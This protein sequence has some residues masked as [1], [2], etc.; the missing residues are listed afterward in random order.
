MNIGLVFLGN[1]A[2]SPLARR[3]GSRP[4]VAVSFALIAAGLGAM[5]LARGVP[6]IFAGEILMGLAS[7]IGYPVMMGLSIRYVEE[8]QRATAMGLFQAVYAVGMFSGPWLSGI[9]ADEIGIQLM[10]AIT[11]VVCLFLGL[12][13]TR[14]LA[15]RD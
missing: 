2:V 1:L 14:L 4:L 7:G 13:G 3:F 12:G 9:V 8:S 15:A 11:G 5:A 6:M 10:F